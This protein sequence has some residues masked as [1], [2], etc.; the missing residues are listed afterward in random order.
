MTAAAAEAVVTPLH[1]DPH[2]LHVRL[3][4][5]PPT[6]SIVVLAPSMPT[7]LPSVTAT[8]AAAASVPRVSL[9]SFSFQALFFLSDYTPLVHR[10]KAPSLGAFFISRPKSPV[11]FLPWYLAP[12]ICIGQL[13]MRM[14][15]TLA[16]MLQRIHTCIYSDVN[17]KINIRMS[18]IL[19]NS[20]P[21]FCSCSENRA[22]NGV[23]ILL[24]ALSEG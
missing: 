21:C 2:R 17:T 22:R 13:S 12:H 4:L 16:H 20:R 19:F 18:R 10:D 23:T 7:T 6:T 11:E 9:R 24:N 3:P 8:I 1:P 14:R 5:Y 15:T